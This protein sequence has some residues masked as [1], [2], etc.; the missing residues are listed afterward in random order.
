MGDR[1]TDHGSQALQAFS[2]AI[3]WLADAPDSDLLATSVREVIVEASP[4]PARI[5]AARDAVLT[6]AKWRIETDPAGAAAIKREALSVVAAGPSAGEPL[7][8]LQAHAVAKAFKG[9][10]WPSKWE[11]EWRG[12][13]D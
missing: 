13:A 6:M 11:L 1:E 10:V 9:C 5:A 3:D 12:D 7:L 4:G 2:L 8:I